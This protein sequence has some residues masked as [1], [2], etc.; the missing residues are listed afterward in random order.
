MGSLL[1]QVYPSVATALSRYAVPPARLAA[2]V[3][4]SATGYGS[5]PAKRFM[6]TQ[7][8][9]ARYKRC[10]KCQAL[11]RALAEFCPHCGLSMP[12][13]FPHNPVVTGETRK[14]VQ[15]LTERGESQHPTRAQM[16]ARYLIVVARGRDDLFEYLRQKFLA[17]SGVE[18]RYD[19]RSAERRQRGQAVKPL[20]RRR[21][22]RRARLPVDVE[23]QRFG[24]AVV[25]RK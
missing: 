25:V 21:R 8:A 9:S 18:V 22:D 2:D 10:P 1:L 17:E 14:V 3:H 16:T 4:A 23:L 20:D 6:R 7:K 11:L 12:G 13:T 15:E 5:R 24:F 19:R